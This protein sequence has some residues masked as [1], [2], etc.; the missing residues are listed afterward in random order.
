MK[1]PSR[2]AALSLVLEYLFIF[3]TSRGQYRR[4]KTGFNKVEDNFFNAYTLQ[5]K[6]VEALIALILQLKQVVI[7]NNNPL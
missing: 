4:P 5:K 3:Y 6:G 7:G 1:M 2:D